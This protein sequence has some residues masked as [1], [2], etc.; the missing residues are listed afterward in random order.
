M[1][2]R[3]SILLIVF[4][5][6]LLGTLRTGIPIVQAD[7]G[8]PN[9]A[10]VAGVEG[11][12]G[13]IDV[14]Q[15]K[16]TQTIKVDGDP[17][18]VALSQD[19]RFLYATQPTLHR[20]SIIAAKTGELVCSADIPGEPTLVSFD[21]NVK[22]L[23]V[24]G[25]KSSTV[26]IVD[27]ENCTIKKRIETTGP[28]YGLA[29]AAVG[30]AV[31]GKNGEQLWVSNE[32]SIS[33]YDDVSGKS[34]G[35]VAMP[36]GPRYLSIPPGATIYATTAQGSVVSID[37]GSHHIS[38]LISGGTY[39]PMDFDE[40]TGE[41]YVP[42]Q[43]NK[44]L[45]VLTPVN[46][47]FDVPKEPHRIFKLNTVPNSVAITSDGQLGFAALSDGNVAM[48][49]IPGQSLITMIKA[50]GSPQFIITGLYPP[51]FGTTP[52]Q[53]SLFDRVGNIIGYIIVL[54]LLIVPFVLF[55]RYSKVRKGNSA[56][57]EQDKVK[58]KTHSQQPPE[59]S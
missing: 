29:Y 22:S 21:P 2:T 49:D 7:G 18:L 43:T 51:T 46:A 10:Y 25:N 3:K 17:K 12:V 58:E 31:S 38:P 24:A 55:R 30:S 47:G 8:A 45:V 34:L 32:K 56:E 14:Q 16:I 57:Q 5:A 44:Q 20:M 26:T 40:T 23:Y 36:Q 15:Q 4:V 1:G 35:T 48:Y 9:L 6:F 28:V 27:A 52:S 41:V 33:I 19:G 54:V 59:V 37:M 42:D 11:G 39:G 13:V 53:A 50:G